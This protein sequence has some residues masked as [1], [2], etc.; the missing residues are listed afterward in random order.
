L[1]FHW[2]RSWRLVA[3]LAI[4]LSNVGGECRLVQLPDQPFTGENPEMA[5]Y[6]ST[7]D[8][9]ERRW[10]G[11]KFWRSALARLPMTGGWPL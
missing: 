8:R 7:I 10:A 5:F 11:R 9:F 1:D 6:D 2:A 4:L 3:F